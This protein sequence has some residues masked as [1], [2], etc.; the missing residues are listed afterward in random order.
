MKVI[1][2]E[3]ERFG[4]LTVICRTSQPHS[5]RNWWWC[6]C[7]CGGWIDCEASLLRKGNNKSC[8]CL[9]KRKNRDD[10]NKSR[11]PLYNVWQMIYSRCYRLTCKEYKYYGG[12]GITMCETWRSDFWA[13]V[14]DMGPKP[15]GHNHER[16]YSVDR[17]DNDGNYEP[18]NV[19]WSTA[20]E[21]MNN[22]RVSKKA[23]T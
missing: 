13:F 6:E 10:D 11:H 5:H 3:G 4:K 23:K 17:V 8:G 16:M 20:K 22:T 21:Q 2:H 9:S 18:S 15:D 19:K 14:N 1:I 12:R 7:D